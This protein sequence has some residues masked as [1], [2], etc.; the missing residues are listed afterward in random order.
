[1]PVAGK[2]AQMTDEE[3]KA[4]VQG[5]V[6]SA[7]ADAVKSAIGEAIKPLVEAQAELVKNQKVLADT[8]AAD[9]ATAQKVIDDAAKATAEAA[10]KGEAA[11]PLTA[12]DV[13]K[14]V[15]D[16]VAKAQTA[17][18]QSAEQKAQRD[19]FVND[20]KNGIAKLPAPFKAQLGNDPAKWADEA[21]KLS[22]E[23]EQFA[24]DNKIPLPSVGGA[25]REGGTPPG[26]TEAPTASDNARAKAAKDYAW[27]KMPGQ[28]QQ[29]AAPAA[30]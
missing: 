9:K 5:T 18:Q 15:A 12:D 22:G 20:P 21:K 6:K 29:P 1:M 19:A 2:E 24:K 10:K 14:L 4:L 7:T 8:F 27:V 3:I 11:K 17:Q 13:A 28:A 26:G 25:T 16:S 23:W 30:A